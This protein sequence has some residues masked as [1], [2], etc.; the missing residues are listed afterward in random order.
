LRVLEEALED[1][2]AFLRRA[3]D[4]K[5]PFIPRGRQGVMRNSILRW[6]AGKTS[7]KEAR[8]EFIEK[9]KKFAVGHGEVLDQFDKY[10]QAYESSGVKTSLARMRVRVRLPDG[11]DP[12]FRI[13]AEVFRLDRG[14][15]G[16]YTAWLASRQSSDWDETI[17]L[18]LLHDSV[19][20]HLNLYLDEVEIAVYGFI[21]GT[22]RRFNFTEAQIQEARTALSKLLERL[23]PL[24]AKEQMPTEALQEAMEF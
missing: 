13:G 5:K 19:A 4:K 16:V 14:T 10:V 8:A 2:E 20:E 18:P 3:Q 12:R 1:P 21:D 7:A 9:C 17:V 6:H 24:V 22:V 23:A 15:E 11:A